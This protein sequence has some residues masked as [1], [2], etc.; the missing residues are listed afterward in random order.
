MS[1]DDA[2]RAR[3]HSV[4]DE[5]DDAEMHIADAIRLQVLLDGITRP[6]PGD[7]DDWLDAAILLAARA[8]NALQAG[9]WA[10][11]IKDRYRPDQ[12]L[13]AAHVT[14]GKVLCTC[15]HVQIDHGPRC[16]ACTDDLV[17]PEAGPARIVRGQVRCPDCGGAELRLYGG[18]AGR[19]AGRS[20][21][22]L[23]NDDWHIVFALGL[24]EP[25]Q[26]PPPRV[27]TAPW[28]LP[29]VQCA[30][31]QCRR[32]V[33]VP[34]NVR[35]TFGD[36]TIG[37]PRTP[38]SDDVA[39]AASGL[40][41]VHARV[42]G[43]AVAFLCL[44]PS[45]DVAR[46]RTLARYASVAEPGSV[47]ARPAQRP[48]GERVRTVEPIERYDRFHVPAGSVGVVTSCEDQLCAVRLDEPVPGMGHW[49]NELYFTAEDAAAAGVTPPT[50]ASA[51]WASC[52]PEPL[53]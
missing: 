25:C 30:K 41:I 53:P 34:E 3:G 23:A 52:Q 18:T 50:A 7:D 31:D 12:R 49:D 36:W 16:E 33:E 17:I 9:L 51:M 46:A 35:V 26:P 45:S 8:G 5:P 4:A 27:G 48:I 15:G 40:H 38:P 24:G 29:C 20:V 10:M 32:V 6:R 42:N 47:Q 14:E 21:A 28:R 37:Q 2:D 13:T 1:D 11:D 22:M 39:S 43:I 44:L 19:Q